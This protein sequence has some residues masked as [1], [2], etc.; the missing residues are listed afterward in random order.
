MAQDAV[1]TRGSG[2][3]I[4]ETPVRRPPPC[5]FD[6]ALAPAFVRVVD[7]PACGRGLPHGTDAVDV[8]AA[9]AELDLEQGAPGIGARLRGH[10][11]RRRERQGVGGFDGAGNAAQPRGHGGAGR[12]RIEI[13]QR[14]IDGVA[15]RAGRQ[16]LRKLRPRHAGSQRPAHGLDGCHHALDRL[17]IAPVGN[18]FAATGV[19]PFANRAGDDFGLRLGA[20]R[21]GEGA[22]DGETLGFDR[23]DTRHV[24][25]LRQRDG[26]AAPKS[27]GRFV[28]LNRTP[29]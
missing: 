27:T 22:R 18:T 19:A 28:R 15:R 21:D 4:S 14:A 25:L 29:C 2:C 16:R 9:A 11:L 3:S 17:A 23:N 26:R 5:W 8:F 10:R 20:A 6:V 12:L 13:P 24:F 1:L 7:E